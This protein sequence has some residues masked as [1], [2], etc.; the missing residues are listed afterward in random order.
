MFSGGDL[1]QQ[2]KA[3]LG[4]IG[5]LLVFLLAL[6]SIF[7]RNIGKG[8]SVATTAE[9]KTYAEQQAAAYGIPPDIFLNLITTE[10]NWNPN[11]VSPANAQGIA[12]L[13]PGTA[14][15]INRFD[16]FASLKYA[17]QL[18]SSYFAKY[19]DWSLALAAYNAGPGAVATYGGV[20]PYAETQD[21]VK[22]ILGGT[23]SAESS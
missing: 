11:A 6:L 22:K 15:N 3:C 18:L 1:V 16:P 12:Q 7:G 13:E 20:P 23:T 2:P 8:S 19:G 9:L 10:S 14:P 21:Y 17:A 5:F 4:N